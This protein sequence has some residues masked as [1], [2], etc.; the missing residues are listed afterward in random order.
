MDKREIDEIFY[1]SDSSK[2]I[3]IKVKDELE[4]SFIAYAMAV[5]VS[6]AIP[7][8]RDGLK[9]VHRRILYAMGELNLSNDKPYKKC[10]RIVGDVMGKYHPHGDGAIYDALVRMAQDFS[11][12]LPLIDGHG[13]F[14]SVDGDSAAAQRYTEARLSKISGI[15]LDGIDQETVDFYPN[16]DESELQPVVLPARFPNLLV[17]GSDGIAVGMATNIPPHNLGEVVDGLVALINDPNMDEEDL[18]RIIPAPDFPTKGLIMGGSGIKQAYRTGRGKFLIRAKAEIEEYANGTRSRIVITEI[19]Y[20]VNK[21]KLIIQIAD[22]VKNKRIEGISDIKEESDREGMRIVIEVK[23]DANAQVVLNMLYKHTQCQ[24]SFGIIMLALV[25]GTPKVLNLMEVLKHYLDF[26]KEI[27]VRRTKFELDKAESKAHILRGL[28][29]AQ[30]NIDEVIRQI[31]LSEDKKEAVEKLVTLFNLDEKQATA[32]LDM[33]LQRLTGLEVEKL[34][35]ELQSC[36]NLIRELKE[37]LDSETKVMAIIK[38]DLQDIKASYAVPRKSEISLDYGSID[39]ADLIEEETVVIS[40]THGGYIKRQPVSEYKSQHRGGIGVSAHKTKEEDFVEN[41]FI[42]STHD[43]LLFFSN[44]GKVYTI[45][46]YEVPES[47]RQSKG[48]ALINMLQL[49]TGERITTI[50]PV[51]ETN[52]ETEGYLMM[53]TKQGLIKKTRLSEFYSIRKSGKIAIKLVDDDQ[54]I[55]VYLTNG[56]Q[57]VLLASS[58][59]KCI[60]FNENDVRVMGRD[61]QGV[62]SIRLNSDESVVDMV[63]VDEEKEML[64]ISE[65][66]YGKRTNQAEYRTQSRY[67][68]GIKAGIFNEQTGALINLKQVGDDDDIMLIGDNG[69]IIRIDSNEINTIGRNTKGVR[70]MRLRDDTKIVSVAITPSE[71]AEEKLASDLEDEQPKSHKIMEL[72]EDED[73]DTNVDAEL[74]ENDGLDAALD[75]NTELNESD[76]VDSVSDRDSDDDSDNDDEK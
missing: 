27:I 32:I 68:K 74:E 24:V 23:R 60:R 14:G 8:V 53:A 25:N 40:L 41:I 42:T 57:D 21:A 66:G 64:T 5:N 19:P 33:R 67:G 51:N 69:Q 61:T 75:E 9:P 7:D 62:K 22:M 70:V 44:M 6:R 54:L 31:K 63:V 12:N 15:M 72:D 11:I 50:I 13:N 46:A 20:Q 17:N 59:G 55:N 45:R 29:I 56:K 52:K 39:I 35:L 2:I 4:K 10:A 34:K 65:N 37:I 49:D 58:T 26:Q 73:I 38:R 30:A 43:D 3:N 71:Q 48:R 47:V 28:V 18:F 1:K 16:F 36:E 76:L